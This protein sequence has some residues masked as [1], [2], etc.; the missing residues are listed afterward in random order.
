MDRPAPERLTALRRRH[1]IEPVK[2][3]PDA[4][5]TCKVDDIRV[6]PVR[7]NQWRHDPEQMAALRREAAE[8]VSPT[9]LR[10]LLS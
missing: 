4:P 3:D 5:V 10:R 2:P 1:R 9:E 8:Q 7:G 6:Y